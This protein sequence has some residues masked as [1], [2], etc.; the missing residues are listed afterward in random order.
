MLSRR[1]F[2]H[3]SGMV[4]AGLLA[5]DQL[6]ILDKLAPRSLF[7]SAGIEPHRP[8]TVGGYRLTGLSGWGLDGSVEIFGRDGTL[9]GRFPIVNGITQLPPGG[10]LVDQHD[11]IWR[12]TPFFPM[13]SRYSIDMYASEA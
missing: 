13:P 1:Q 5:A 11:V 9:R 6:E 8:V 12:S 4:A 3:Y 7:A 10:V 2:L